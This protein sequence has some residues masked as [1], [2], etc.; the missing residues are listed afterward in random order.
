VGLQFDPMLA[1]VVAHG[2]TRAEAAGRLALALERLHLGGVA[3]NRD[4]LAATLRTPAFLAGETTTDFIE[5]VAPAPALDLDEADLQRAAAVA[6]LWLQGETR[7]GATVL[8]GLP[9]GWRNGR[10]PPQKAVFAAGERTVEVEYASQRDGSFVLADGAARVHHWAPTAI[11][12]EVDGRRAVHA[13]TRS[14][15][16]LH[17]QVPRGTVELTVRP[18]FVPP[19]GGAA[20]GGFVAS[21]PGVVLEVRVAAGDR[22]TA[23]QTVLV[24]EAMKMEHH[25]RAAADGVVAAVHVAAGQQVEKG[26][27]LLVIDE[28]GEN[29]EATDG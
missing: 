26:A 21:M 6:A 7:A 11:D 17:V 19:G 8:A 14:G 24:L 15:D 5:R 3:T 23:G 9:T 16:R 4:F 25:M 18:R 1:K 12:A 29:G 2:P 20:H 22:V 13:V 27:V 28:G 10:L